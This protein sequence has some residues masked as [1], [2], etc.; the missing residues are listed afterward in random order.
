MFAS[1]YRCLRNKPYELIGFIS[2]TPVAQRIGL[3]CSD[4]DRPNL[5]ILGLKWSDLETDFH[6]K[7]SNTYEILFIFFFFLLGGGGRVKAIMKI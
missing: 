1:K 3:V 5:C 2:Q 4:F 6:R 7:P